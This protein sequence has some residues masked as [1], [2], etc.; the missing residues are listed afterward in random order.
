MQWRNVPYMCPSQALLCSIKD[1]RQ[2]TSA[3]PLQKARV[4]V[5]LSVERYV[6]CEGESEDKGKSESE[7]EGEHGRSEGAQE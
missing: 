1:T 4:Q 2:F 3:H 6:K 7:S 5:L